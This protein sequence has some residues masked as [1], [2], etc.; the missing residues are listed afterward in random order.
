MSVTARRLAGYVKTNR[1]CRSAAIKLDIRQIIEAGLLSE[2][3]PIAQNKA[4]RNA[5]ERL[6]I[7]PKRTG[8][9]GLAGKWT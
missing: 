9:L 7:E 6:G 2:G 4:F 8:G 1:P 3:K 5:K